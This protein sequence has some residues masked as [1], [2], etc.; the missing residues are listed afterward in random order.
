MDNVIDTEKLLKM[1]NKGTMADTIHP[2]QLG[3][4]ILAQEIY[5]RLAYN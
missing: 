1:Q 4:G 5:M 2:N 3:Y